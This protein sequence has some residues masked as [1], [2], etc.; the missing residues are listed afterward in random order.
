MDGERV[1]VVF[2][3]S[4]GNTQKVA[5]AIAEPLSADIEQ[6]RAVNP[7]RVDIKGKG[8]GNFLNMGRAVFAAITGRAT[9]IEQAQYEP[10][11]YSLVVVGTPVYAGCVPGPVRAYLDQHRSKLK[12]VAFFCTGEDP[13]NV[14][15]FEQMEEVCGRAPKAVFAFHAP[16]VRANE[17]LPQVEEFIA[18][19]A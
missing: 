17:F 14:R 3:S 6:I 8:L 19:M 10:A 7:R 5:Q 12:E 13:N 9:P 15:V 1:L 2:H 16:K 11:G 18:S 4:S